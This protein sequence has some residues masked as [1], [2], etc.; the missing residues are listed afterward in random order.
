MDVSKL[1]REQSELARKAILRDSFGT[2]KRIGG[3]DCSYLDDEWVI[4]GLVVLD[5]DT[6]KPVYRTY[7]VQ[8]LSF[9]YV[10]GL[11]AYREGEAMIGVIKKAKVKPD[12]IMVDGFGTNHPRRCG[13]ATHIGIKLDM[14]TI[15][16]GK[17]FLC[18]RIEGN[19][20][21]QDGEKA[22]KM[23]YAEGSKRPIYVSPGHRIS[24]ETAADIV[25]ACISAGRIPGPARLAHEYVTKLRRILAGR[26]NKTCHT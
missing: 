26:A 6:L 14:P 23:I 11:L 20:V 2:I 13:I 3:V 17:S 21:Y 9:P 18:G 8:K 4:A 19:Y 5:Y 25:S 24:L 12:I 7:E 16:V 22:G 10:P 15:G 1:Y